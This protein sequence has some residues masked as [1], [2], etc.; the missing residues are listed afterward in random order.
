MPRS[1]VERALVS[2]SAF[3]SAFV[4]SACILV[5]SS[6]GLSSAIPGV[7]TLPMIKTVRR[8]WRN[9]NKLIVVVRFGRDH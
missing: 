6:P 9:G 1:R 2:A 3:A 8:G 7:S 4:A 5:V